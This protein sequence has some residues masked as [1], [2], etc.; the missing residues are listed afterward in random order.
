M[1]PRTFPGRVFV[2]AQPSQ[3]AAHPWDGFLTGPEN[4]LA[5]A[6]VSALARGEGEGISPLVVYGPSGVGKSRLLGG[7]VA[8]W[9]RREPGSCL[10]HLE[11]ET[12]VAVCAEATEHAGGWAD[13]RAQFRQLD[14]FVLEDV[15][16]LERAPLALA[17][18]THTLDA[19]SE[20][21]AAIAV[22]ARVGPAQW[23]GWP[24]RL[25]NRLLGGLV[26]RL[27]P[28]TLASRRRYVFDRA[29]ARQVSLTAEAAETLAEAADGYRTLDGWLARLA[30]A[31][32][33]D[34]RAFDRDLIGPMLAEEGAVG[35]LTIDQIARAV[36]AQFGV[37]LSELRAHSRR[38][39]VVGPRH[40]AMHLARNTTGLSFGA[41]GAYFGRRDP[42]TVRH[43]CRMAAERMAAD[44][45]L[46]ATIDT[47]R[48]AWR[49]S[50]DDADRAAG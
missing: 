28:P 47:L 5:W 23:V 4:G 42:A 35:P 10:A 14:L 16:A 8:E 40:L 46:L 32:R 18:L 17:E 1:D 9:M 38:K 22:S 11:A 26:V 49:G 41:I 25:V 13:L 19:L 21:G 20:V 48:L 27:D 45:A 7:L 33:I 31:G 2:D 50:Q 43:A 6:S 15:H 12:F 37:R 3:P 36:A 29:R 39:V 30:L 44:P 24:K 34:R